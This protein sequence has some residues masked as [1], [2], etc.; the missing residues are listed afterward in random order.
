MKKTYFIK[1]LLMNIFIGLAIY[2]ALISLVANILYAI[3]TN[4][5]IKFPSINCNGE[6]LTVTSGTFIK[7]ME[8]VDRN[9]R[10]QAFKSVY[11]TYSGFK[12]TIAALF[13]AQIKQQRFFSKVRGFD[14]NITRALFNNE[15]PVTVYKNLI[16]TVN[17]RKNICD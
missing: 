15:V 12:N 2:I 16:N 3:F 4:A 1:I 8:S 9:I 5:D 17:K 13:D 14:S 10:E 11:S 7:Y 6:S